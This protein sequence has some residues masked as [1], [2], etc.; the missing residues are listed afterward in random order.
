MAKITNTFLNLFLKIGVFDLIR[1]LNK[2]SLTVLN[3]HRIDDP[4]RTDFNTFK[5]NVSATPFQF[6]KQMEY[7]SSKY[8]IVSGKEISEW[9]NNGRILPPHAAVITF[10]DGYN[11]NLI[12]AYPV[13][14]AFDLPA[15]IFLTTDF[16]DS[17]QPFYW[18]VVAYAF[19][20]S[21][22]DNAN[23]PLL[24]NRHWT[25]MESRKEIMDDWI[26][27]VKL[28]PESDKKKNVDQL[29]NILHVSI[30]DDLSAGLALTW[31]GI[32]HLNKNG[33]EMGSHTASHPILT[34]ISLDEV[35]AE[36]EKSKYRIET[37]IKSPVTSF[38]YPNG[39][40]ND[41]N[42]DIVKLVRRT[43]YHIA[44][45]LLQGPTRYTS[46]R[47]NPHTIRRIFLSYKDS[48]PKFVGKL[49]G[50]SRFSS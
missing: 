10:D 23:F 36:L 8:N 46:V 13:L 7:L 21:P 19:E 50:L 48:F 2:N 42:E 6:E 26:A 17:S 16:I 9:V 28:L 37:E 44:F 20:K 24:G 31:S 29:P 47:K 40:H 12:N 45:T 49:M 35:K 39:Q 34:R 32:R 4:F 5:S 1:N 30:P 11:D 43:G 41:F 15:T 38:A 3:Y 22:K 25:D 14:K 18:D 33:I 27:Q